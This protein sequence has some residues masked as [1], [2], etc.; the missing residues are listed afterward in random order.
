MNYN[1]YNKQK[2]YLGCIFNCYYIY[3]SGK[4]IIKKSIQNIAI[5]IMILDN[6]YI[7]LE[8]F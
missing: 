3:D 7:I 6:R 5:T 1:I 4:Y 8:P 2:I